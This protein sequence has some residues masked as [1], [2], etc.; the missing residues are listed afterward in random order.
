LNSERRPSCAILVPSFRRSIDLKRCLGALSTQSVSPDQIIV[1]VRIEDIDTRA[2]VAS[3][4]TKL[5][6]T[7]VLS[8]CPGQV[9]ALNAGLRAVRCDITAITD[10]DTA[11]R[12]DWIS[13]LLEHFADPRVAAVGGRDV[14][15]GPEDE[16]HPAVGLVRW[17]GRITG[18]HHRGIGS[19]RPVDVLKGANMAFRTDW[20]R[21][22]GFDERLRGIG[23][24]VHNDL[25]ICLQIRRAGGCLLYDPD[26]IVDH[27]M[28]H[29]PAGDD[30]TRGTLGAV[31]D[32]V[33]NETLAL[34]EFLPTWRRP[35]WLIAAVLWGTRRNPGLGVS[36]ALLPRRRE[37][38]LSTLMACCRGRAAGVLTWWATRA[39]HE[40]SAGKTP[41]AR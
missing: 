37:S 40:A 10:D 15:T 14:L 4:G 1:V 9:A 22:F 19:V 2:V 35:L 29:R 16:R 18:N 7:E 24:Q 30:R 20:L 28:T 5:A 6:I 17:Y 33:H 36:L 32:E 27:Y 13:R 25:I 34:M 39:E 41:R 38:V 12:S 8:G 26:L 11:P 3:A 31:S 21:R 23:A